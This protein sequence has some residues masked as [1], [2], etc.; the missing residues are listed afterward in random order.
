L[1]PELLHLEI[2]TTEV[3][4]I[5]GVKTMGNGEFEVQMRRQGSGGG[6]QSKRLERLDGQWAAVR[7]T[8][9]KNS[10]LVAY[11]LLLQTPRHADRCRI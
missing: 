3:V 5:I 8:A 4:K 7:S 2:E 1:L 6:L 10:A 11:I 9:S